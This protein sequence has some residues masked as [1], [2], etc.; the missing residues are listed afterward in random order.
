MSA[1]ILTLLM[2]T[3]TEAI[4]ADLGYQSD[5]KIRRK[6]QNSV[7]ARKSYEAKKTERHNLLQ[8]NA[9]LLEMQ[10]QLLR[11]KSL[12]EKKVSLLTKIMSSI[13]HQTCSFARTRDAKPLAHAPKSS[14]PTLH[15]HHYGDDNN[16]ALDLSTRSRSA[17][18]HQVT[19]CKDTA[20]D[21]A[22]LKDVAVGDRS[23]SARGER[24]QKT[25]VRKKVRFEE[26]LGIPD[27]TSD[28]CRIQHDRRR[29]HQNDDHQHKGDFLAAGYVE[30]VLKI[31][32]ENDVQD[33][34]KTE[35]FSDIQDA[36]NIKQECDA[37]DMCKNKQDGVHEIRTIRIHDSVV[38]YS[39]KRF[40]CQPYSIHDHTYP[41]LAYSS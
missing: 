10:K 36:C 22:G 1:L 23:Q 35:Q 11:D 15:K 41:K 16:E 2:I 26:C 24:I 19:S 25:D 5:R 20:R 13:D 4:N 34:C 17:V 40:K 28:I 31:K 39:G 21:H 9:A 32:Q 30:R 6:Q 29:S 27:S 14:S 12:L 8:K 18:S 33:I 3:G 37:H 7:A 38:A